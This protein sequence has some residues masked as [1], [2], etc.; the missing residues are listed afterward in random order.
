[1]HAELIT[2]NPAKQKYVLY[3]TLYIVSK[4]YITQTSKICIYIFNRLLF[5]VLNIYFQRIKLIEVLLKLIYV[6]LLQKRRQR[7]R[8]GR[9]KNRRQQSSRFPSNY[10]LKGK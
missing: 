1:M 7:D 2:D 10:L 8:K 6:C 3:L 5:I 4:P 9:K